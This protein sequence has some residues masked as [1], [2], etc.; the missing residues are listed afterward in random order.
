MKFRIVLE[1]KTKKG[2]PVQI[3]FKVPPS[4]HKGLINFL[5]IALEHENDVIFTVERVAEEKHELSKIEGNF[6]LHERQTEE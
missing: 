1:T 5:N 4:K 2:N 6:Q 3:K